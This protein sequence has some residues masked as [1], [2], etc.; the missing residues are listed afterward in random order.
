VVID[1][2]SK[3]WEETEMFFSKTT[4]TEENDG[5]SVSRLKIT[6]DRYSVAP[7]TT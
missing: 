6:E 5:K 1:Q 3:L 7:A 4:G 2:R